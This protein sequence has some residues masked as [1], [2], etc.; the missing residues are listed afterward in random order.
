MICTHFLA[1]I[2]ISNYP[3]PFR[4]MRRVILWKGSFD[5]RLQDV[6]QG[7]ESHGDGSDNGVNYKKDSNILKSV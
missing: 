6:Q 1:K 4:S 7:A 2:K 3:R 5:S